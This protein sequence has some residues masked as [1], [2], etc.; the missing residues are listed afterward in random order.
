[1]ACCDMVTGTG[2]SLLLWLQEPIGRLLS[3][4]QETSNRL[5]VWSRA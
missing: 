1:M 2:D 5:L 4:L 3:S